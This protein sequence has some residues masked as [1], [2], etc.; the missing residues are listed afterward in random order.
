MDAAA[1]VGTPPAFAAPE[2]TAAAG[3]ADAAAAG[4]VGVG[5]G[6]AMVYEQS[7]SQ[8]PPAATLAP[9]TWAAATGVLAPQTPRGPWSPPSTCTT[10]ATGTAT[11]ASKAN[12]SGDLSALP[13]PP[14]LPALPPATCSPP[15]ADA[16][17]PP[18]LPPP[19]YPDTYVVDGCSGSDG[20]RVGRVLRKRQRS[21]D[22]EYLV[23]YFKAYRTPQWDGG[24]K[25]SDVATAAAGSE[26][27]E[28]EGCTEVV[29]TQDEEWVSAA[30]GRVGKSVV[31]LSLAEQK[32]VW[33]LSE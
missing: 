11:V 3:A 24:V 4:G 30:S 12:D 8:V 27:G 23:R 21:G 17:P 7:Q 29:Y 33:F 2:S 1:M 9:S 19:S 5:G 22:E 28:G 26:E 13:V 14:A 6:G 18:R 31:V 15:A 16:A 10:T 25:G 20:S 32:D